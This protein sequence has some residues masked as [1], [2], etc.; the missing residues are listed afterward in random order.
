MDQG[1]GGEA[2][3]RAGQRIPSALEPFEALSSQPAQTHPGG[4]TDGAVLCRVAPVVAFAGGR[5]DDRRGDAAFRHAQGKRDAPRAFA[6]RV[7]DVGRVGF[8]IAVW[9]VAARQAYRV[10]GDVAPGGWVVIAAEVVM[11]PRLVIK[12]L[13]RQTEVGGDRGA[14]RRS[15]GR[16]DGGLA[17]HIVIRRPNDIA[18]FVGGLGRRVEVEAGKSCLVPVGEVKH[19]AQ[20]ATNRVCELVFSLIA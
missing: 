8:A 2:V 3:D 1:V 10:L 5:V 16:G 12:V 17:E 6:G 11:Q 18:V 15:G 13:P 20:Y 4:A 14:V 9:V 7:A 19:L